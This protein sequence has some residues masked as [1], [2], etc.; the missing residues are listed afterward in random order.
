M[1][2]K[3]ICFTPV[4]GAALLLQLG[5]C[6]SAPSAQTKFEKT[7]IA[8]LPTVVYVFYEM[9]RDCTSDGVPT[10]LV[11]QPASHGEI[12]SQETKRFPEY[13]SSNPRSECNKERHPSTVV[14]YTPALDY[15]GADQFSIKA[16][17]HNGQTMERQFVF[18]VAGKPPARP[19]AGQQ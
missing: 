18:T 4:I 5:G 11:T 15:V 13:P 3:T 8:G 14:L 17:F 10:V 19:V 12:V 16:V 1:K 6:V 9:Q 7:A 2:N